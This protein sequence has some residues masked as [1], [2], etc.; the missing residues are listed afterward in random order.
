MFL[1][2]YMG[3]NWLYYFNVL[4]DKIKPLMLG[5]NLLYYFNVLYVKIEPLMLSVL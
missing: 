4:Y 2:V 5:S 3:R 1:W